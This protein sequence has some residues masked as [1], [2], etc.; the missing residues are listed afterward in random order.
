MWQDNGYSGRHTWSEAWDYCLYLSLNNY[1]D[2]R[3]PDENELVGLYTRRSILEQ[4]Y[5]PRYWSASHQII[6]YEKE[7]V[8]VDF[9][10]G[11]TFPHMQGTGWLGYVRC[12]RDG[13]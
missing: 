10:Y 8:Y 2:W 6:E 12:V 3:L 9:R 5:I 13:Q 7:G 1:I 11:T 4:Y